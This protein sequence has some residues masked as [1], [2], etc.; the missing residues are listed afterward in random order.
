MDDDKKKLLSDEEMDADISGM[1]AD[2]ADDGSLVMPGA[3]DEADATDAVSD[4]AAD[5]DEQI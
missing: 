4:V 1:T 3:A 2:V 5:E